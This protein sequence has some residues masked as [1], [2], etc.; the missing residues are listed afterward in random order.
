MELVVR[1]TPVLHVTHK[2]QHRMR[3]C[4]QI[5][6][7]K[8]ISC[9]SHQSVYSRFT[10]ICEVH[11]H[12]SSFVLQVGCTDI[13]HLLRSLHITNNGT[14][15]GG[16]SII[17]RLL[18]LLWKASTSHW[19]FIIDVCCVLPLDETQII[20][21]A[22][23]SA[24]PLA[25]ELQLLRC[26]ARLGQAKSR[27][28]QRG[29]REGASEVLNLLL[30][31]PGWYYWTSFE[32]ELAAISRSSR[33]FIPSALKRGKCSAASSASDTTWLRECASPIPLFS[34]LPFF[35]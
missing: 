19:G 35:F 18:W 34:W 11:P 17:S 32:A 12:D 28:Q 24:C 31:L 29:G 4:I 7:K 23:L 16:I 14:T 1:M 5:K 22:S 2:K 9:I 8:F 10:I 20:G 13:S 30:Q 26:G 15:I 21:S 3:K 27:Q 33:R 6:R 25:E